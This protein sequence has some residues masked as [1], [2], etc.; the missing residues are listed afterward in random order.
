MGKKEF[1]VIALNPG[2]E[3]FVVHI[4]SLK[5]PSQESNVHPSCKAQ[6]AALVANKA[7][8]SIPTEYS[9]FADVF[10][11]ELALKLPKHIEIND[12]AIKLVY[13]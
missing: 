3:T 7:S 2:H 11:P 12:H 10:S 4:A 9:D 6:I 8:T 1:A 13:N 5:S